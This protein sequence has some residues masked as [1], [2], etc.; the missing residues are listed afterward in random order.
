MTRNHTP[1]P[2]ARKRHASKATWG[3]HEND[4][5]AKRGRD[6]K[7]VSQKKIGRGVSTSPRDHPA[8]AIQWLGRE[9]G[10]IPVV[11]ASDT[12]DYKKRFL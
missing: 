7:T 6:I 9:S 12:A 2:F 11:V 3:V 1:L 8:L 10:F 4:R 5:G